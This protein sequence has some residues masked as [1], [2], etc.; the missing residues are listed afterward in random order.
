MIKQCFKII[1]RQISKAKTYT[2]INIIG[3]AI[4]FTVSLLLFSHTMNEWNMDR[5]LRDYEHIY[6]ITYKYNDYDT[7]SCR[8][9][10]T[11]AAS[12]KEQLPEILQT[13]RFFSKEYRIKTDAMTDF[14]VDPACAFT[15][16]NF[17]DLFRSAVIQ[18]KIDSTFSSWIVFTKSSA[19]K[20]FNGENPIGKQV[21]MKDIVNNYAQEKK[22]Q[23]IAVIKDF[24]PTSSL[25]ANIFMDHQ[26]GEPYFD[27][28]RG[29][30]S[31]FT[32]LK[33]SPRTSPV[34]IEKALPKIA[35]KM[36]EESEIY[37]LQP[38]KDI[39]FHSTH[40]YSDE[41]L[42]GSYYLTFLLYT[43]MW[44]ILILAISNYSLIRIAQQ[45]K[46][47]AKFAIHKYYGAKNTNILRQ[48]AGEIGIQ[49]CIALLLAYL[50]T[51]LLHPYIIR[52]LSPRHPYALHLPVATNLLFI[53][54]I[55]FIM[56]IV[57]VFLYVYF[58]KRMNSQSIKT[59][60]L[61]SHR[62]MNLAK[63]LT[64]FQISIFTALLF[65]CTVMILQINFIRHKPLGFTPENVLNISWM[66]ERPSYDAIKKELL[67]NP[68][69]LSVCN[70]MNIPSPYDPS[71]E[72]IY[73]PSEPE[74][75]VD[76][77][78]CY[79]D[80]DFTNI[81]HI[82]VI[83]SREFTP[84]ENDPTPENNYEYISDVQ[85]N[86][87]LV[88]T[89]QLEHPIGTIL[90][91]HHSM[92]YR[93]TAVT[94]DFHAHSLHDP[95]RPTMILPP[96]TYLLL[97]RY[98]PGKRQSV[99][100]YLSELHQVYHTGALFEY[101][102][103]SYSDL[104]YKDLSLMQ[105]IIVFALTAILIGSMGIF[106]FSTFIAE[107]K[108]R[109]VAL[110]KVNG[111]TEWQIIQLFNRQ[112]LAKVLLANFIGLPIAYYAS[113][114]WLEDYAYKTEIHAWLYLTVILA[115]TLVVVSITSWQT[116]KAAHKNPI[117]SIKTE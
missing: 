91:Q 26:Q 37:K 116:R 52:I 1:A 99:I 114:K 84:I 23:V 89:L 59:T 95:I 75:F 8:T 100:D 55:G 93:I 61:R 98:Q 34:S 73:F 78:C 54:F 77:V 51:C 81:Y 105:L 79:G 20:Y 10:S 38:I 9:R 111:A 42:R 74:K 65:Y 28:H 109:E 50:L 85:V 110:R 117:D 53:A 19:K 22:F 24:P 35:E 63:T 47:L 70:G 30:F 56:G 5:Y 7:W 71:L 82:P 92:K 57:S 86:R 68:D 27:E 25:Q 112:F 96:S 3:L 60:F 101:S 39:Y 87:K 41:F 97:V 115:S 15:D 107:S 48:I 108:S 6:R 106:A 13:A 14:A 4:A 104:Y 43:I 2:V 80:S 17:F 12:L 46:D 44:I 29:S 83:E 11:L 45:N 103:Y 21:I 64:V 88:E 90:N 40:L 72:R 66:N 36:S 49:T 67:R 62:H 18:G 102:E 33:L 32:F 113:R 94:E 76:A 16:L 31:V 69:I 58:R